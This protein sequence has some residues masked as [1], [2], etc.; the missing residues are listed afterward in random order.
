MLCWV[1]AAILAIGSAGGV[2]NRN[3]AYLVGTA[4]GLNDISLLGNAAPRGSDDA[5]GER[6]IA[7]PFPLPVEKSAGN[8]GDCDEAKDHATVALAST[9]ALSAARLYLPCVTCSCIAVKGISC[10]IDDG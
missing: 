6:S 2:E 9:F 5:I 1:G 8:G 10:S 3:E 4:L 7:L